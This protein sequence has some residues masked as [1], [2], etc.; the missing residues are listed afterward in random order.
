MSKRR[1]STQ[2]T[3]ADYRTVKPRRRKL[4]LQA[5][6]RRARKARA[7]LDYDDER[8]KRMNTARAT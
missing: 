4:S 2:T 3:F 1:R 5:A 8:E 6:L 7:W